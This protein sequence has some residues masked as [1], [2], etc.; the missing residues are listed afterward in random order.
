VIVGGDEK[1]NETLA[2][3]VLVV[4]VAIVDPARAAVTVVHL[5]RIVVRPWL[6]LTYPRRFRRGWWQLSLWSSMGS[7]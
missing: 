1:L 7:D 2:N 3:S 6:V 5:A 4:A